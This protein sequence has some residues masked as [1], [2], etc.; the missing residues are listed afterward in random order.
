[1]KAGQLKHR[2]TFQTP[3]ETH[4]SS[5]LVTTYEDF[6]E[7]YAGIYPIRAYELVSM[8]KLEH[9]ITHKV[10]TRYVSGVTAKMRIVFDSTRYLNI[11]QVINPDERRIMLE[12]MATEEK[13]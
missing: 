3:V 4:G 5:G 9:E 13:S 7:A 11:K 6:K 1:M 8:G 10:R 2:I 12:I